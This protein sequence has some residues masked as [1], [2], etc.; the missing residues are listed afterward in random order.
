MDLH[1]SIL[2]DYYDTDTSKEWQTKDGPNK[3]SSGCHQEGKREE[4][5]Y[6]DERNPRC[7]IREESGTTEWMYREEC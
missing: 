6:M 5:S 4:N 2:D 7:S 3:F 1:N